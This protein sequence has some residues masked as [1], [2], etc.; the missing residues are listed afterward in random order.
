VLV[1]QNFVPARQNTNALYSQSSSVL[2]RSIS[3]YRYG[4]VYS[5]HRTVLAYQTYQTQTPQ[6]QTYNNNIEFKS[7]FS[8]KAA[9]YCRT[10]S[11]TCLDSTPSNLAKMK[12]PSQHSSIYSS[13]FRLLIISMLLSG[14]FIQ[15]SFTSTGRKSI[16]AGLVYAQGEDKEDTAVVQQE[17][18]EDD[19]KNQNGNGAGG[20][21]KNDV[22]SEFPSMQPSKSPTQNPTRRP[23]TRTPTRGPI[24]Q[25]TTT[26]RLPTNSPTV[27]PTSK[28]I[29]T[30][31]EVRLPE[32]SIDITT[33][34]NDIFSF[35]AL[36]LDD[37]N[38]NREGLNIFFQ[39]FVEDLLIASRVVSSSTLESIDLQISLLP[40]KDEDYENEEEDSL[41]SVELEKTRSSSTEFTPMRIVL[42]GTMSYYVEDD[43]STTDSDNNVLLLEDNMSHTL[44]VY[45]S[46][47]TTDEMVTTLSDFGLSDPIITSV[48]VD[49]K[50]ILVVPTTTTSSSGSITDNNGSDNNDNGNVGGN[51]LVVP[52]GND[53]VSITSSSSDGVAAVVSS[54]STLQYSKLLFAGVPALLLV[55]LSDI[56]V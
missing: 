38:N 32:I 1:D 23:T 8:K 22:D 27:L 16:S 21:D 9:D 43:E 47:W 37:G 13:I 11:S 55:L 31:S 26:T 49:G 41:S 30:I 48:S 4:N 54:S 5:Y 42:D 35:A 51:L 24:T 14:D 19:T 39:K 29:T 18:K 2:E 10:S 53:P 20:D 6:T 50:L 15:Y 40:S 25:T 46:F 34:V 36:L 52:N 3:C 33:V 44:A 12:M 45:F 28:A 17:D 56:L 7:P